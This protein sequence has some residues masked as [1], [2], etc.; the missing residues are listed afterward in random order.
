MCSESGDRKLLP[1]VPHE[2]PV[3]AIL[4]SLRGKP[5]QLERSQLIQ[6]IQQQG[7]YTQLT[8]SP[9]F[10]FMSYCIYTVYTCCTVRS[11]K[12]DFD[13][14]DLRGPP[15][16]TQT[17]RGWPNEAGQVHPRRNA[18]GRGILPVIDW[19]K[20]TNFLLFVTET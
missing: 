20:K 4:P 2:H 14:I 8:F 10:F 9:I 11:Y 15:R 6:E 12:V 5:R 19:Q 18:R 13:C 16:D 17:T 1:G 7:K 3:Q